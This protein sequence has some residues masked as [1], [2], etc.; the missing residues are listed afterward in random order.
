MKQGELEFEKT[1]PDRLQRGTHNPNL[2][3][4]PFDDQLTVCAVY[5]TQTG[6]F[7]VTPKGKCTWKARNHAANAVNANPPEW[8]MKTD[9][10]KALGRKY[11]Y[12]QYWNYSDQDRLIIV[13]GTFTIANVEVLD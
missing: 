3:H 6:K 1:L 13:R 7:W 9:D 12:R 11:R 4:Y 5:D 10:E 8:M 2:K